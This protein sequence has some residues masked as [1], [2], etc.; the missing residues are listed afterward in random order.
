M[1]VPN[2]EAKNGG[3]DSGLPR[4]VGLAHKILEVTR[5]LALPV[6]PYAGNKL[7]HG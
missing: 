5:V 1:C 7:I 4:A 3:G 2:L 6:V